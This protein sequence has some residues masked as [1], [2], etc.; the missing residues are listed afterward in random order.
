MAGNVYLD[1]HA[2]SSIKVCSEVVTE[3]CAFTTGYYLSSFEMTVSFTPSV[4]VLDECVGV[5]GVKSD[6]EGIEL[7]VDASV[8]GV[9]VVRGY[10][11]QGLEPSPWLRLFSIQFIA[12][13]FGE[14]QNYY[15]NSYFASGNFAVSV[16]EFTDTS[17]EIVGEPKGVSYRGIYYYSGDFD[18]G[19]ITL[20]YFEW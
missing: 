19:V 18:P 11:A 12:I 2:F 10:Y 5:H 4:M 7:S 17:G 13:D 9:L 16:Q 6:I 3:I 20:P 1:N 14:T 15:G 8:E